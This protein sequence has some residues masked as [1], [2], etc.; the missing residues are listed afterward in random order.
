VKRSI[1]ILLFV[2]VL[3]AGKLEVIIDPKIELLGVIEYLALDEST[4]RNRQVFDDDNEYVREV[5]KHFENY[6][7][8]DAVVSF[9]ELQ[10]K[11]FNFEAPVILL[12]EASNPPDLDVKFPLPEFLSSKAN[13][14]PKVGEQKLFE[15]L[16]EL[17][18]FA[19]ESEFIKFFD[20]HKSLYE[21]IST[22]MAKVLKSEDTPEKLEEFF[23]ESK[24]SYTVILAPL[25]SGG[26]S[27]LNSKEN[28]FVIVGPTKVED[29]LPH[30]CYHRT[31]QF[32]MNAIAFAF[33][34]PIVDDNWDFFAKSAKLYD[35]IVEMMIQ[36]S[37][38]NWQMA[39]SEHFTK[40][41]IL[42]IDESNIEGELNLVSSVSW[43]LWYLPEIDDLIKKEFINRR[44]KYPRFTDFAHKIS[45]LLAEM[46][47][48]PHD[49]ISDR[50][51]A[52]ITVKTT[53]VWAMAEKNCKKLV[54]TDIMTLIRLDME[55]YLDKAEHVFRCFMDT[56]D[57]NDEHYWQ[58]KYQV[59][60]I[61]FMKKDYDGAERI[62]NDYLKNQPDG[63]LAAGAFWRLGQ[64]NEIT[65]D[66]KQAEQLYEHALKLDPNLLQAQQSL[67]RLRINMEKDEQSQ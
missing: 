58:V 34:E 14:N 6:A 57:P 38:P 63:E 60:K 13:E 2:S 45:E 30:F 24:K 40:A 66:L 39:L 51:S 1:F 36:Q 9:R 61:R 42:N 31:P 25:Y 64:I 5:K 29:D 26:Y 11:G 41:A 27:H 3:T 33:V 59:G 65:G 22:P 53:N 48:L 54:F 21:N 47:K 62:F 19:K 23:G 56:Q 43:G 35:H 8:H 50:V 12:L 18:E 20:A 32:V 67:N 10:K 17:R 7:N 49:I 15:W 16:V 37:I 28:S 46:S 44:E 55:L 4:N 52:A